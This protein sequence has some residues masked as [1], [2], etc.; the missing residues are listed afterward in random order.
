MHNSNVKFKEDLRKALAEA[1][2]PIKSSGG[3][4]D[5]VVNGLL[6][7]LIG[8]ASKLIGTAGI[9]HIVMEQFCDCG[10]CT[11]KTVTLI[12][13]DSTPVVKH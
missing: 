5:E 2:E 8:N 1:V 4:L 10:S 3:E 13:K 12:V 11:P 6:E 7:E 9:D